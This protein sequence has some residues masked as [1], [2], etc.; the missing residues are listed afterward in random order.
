MTAAEVLAECHARNIMLQAHG[1]RL[2]IDAPGDALTPDLLARLQAHKPELLAMLAGGPVALPRCDPF[3]ADGAQDGQLR[4]GECLGSG[5]VQK[6]TIDGP[7]WQVAIGGGQS[8]VH[9]V[10][11]HPRH[12]RMPDFVGVTTG[13]PKYERLKGPTV[14]QVA[15]D[16]RVHSFSIGSMSNARQAEWHER[17]TVEGW[18]LVRVDVADAEIHDLQPCPICGCLEIWQDIGGTW[19]CERCE[20]RTAGPRLRELAQRLRERYERRAAG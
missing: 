5:D 13:E 9:A 19:H 8:D 2:D 3:G 15:N 11:Q 14:Q 17:E 20:P 12:F 18:E 1:G 10:S 7:V 4:Q 16:L 6:R